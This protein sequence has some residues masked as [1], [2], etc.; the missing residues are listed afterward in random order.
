[1]VLTEVLN[2]FSDS[3]AYF[4][5]AAARAAASL[6]TSHEVLIVAQTSELF[7]RAFQRYRTMSDKG[8]S[9]TDCASFIIMEDEGIT[10]AL[11]HDHHFV[12]AGF[13]AL[14]R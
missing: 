12:Q 7:A 5:D 11:S 2:N 10:S 1:M 6:R 14:L 9:L 13:Q 8:W 4:R 3:G